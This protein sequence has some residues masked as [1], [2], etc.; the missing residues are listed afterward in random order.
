MQQTSTTCLKLWSRE[1]TVK[2]HNLPKPKS[3]PHNCGAELHHLKAVSRIIYQMS[4]ESL[5]ASL[6][7]RLWQPADLHRL[8]C[9]VLTQTLSLMFHRS[10]VVCRRVTETVLGSVCRRSS[11]VR[12]RAPSWS[13][14][15][16]PSTGWSLASPEEHNCLLCSRWA[17]THARTHTHTHTHTH[18]QVLSYP[19]GL[20]LWFATGSALCL[21]MMENKTRTFF[22]VII[23][24]KTHQN[25]YSNFLNSFPWAHQGLT[26]HAT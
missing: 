8:I 12:I 11:A 1:G 15:A 18:T 13:C 21:W 17:R 16:E 6:P 5:S 14:R 23:L 2:N 24:C 4:S 25:E 22:F 10:V 26:Y 20:T 19:G 7:H 3:K 9:G